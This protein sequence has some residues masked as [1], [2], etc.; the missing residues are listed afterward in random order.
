MVEIVAELHCVY[1]KVD[2]NAYIKYLLVVTELYC[3]LFVY[4]V[5]SSFYLPFVS[6]VF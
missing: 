6:Y 3:A 2:R 4:F 5:K 1:A